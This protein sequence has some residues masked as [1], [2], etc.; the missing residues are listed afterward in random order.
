L[1][2]K[3]G[4]TLILLFA[5]VFALGLIIGRNDHVLSTVLAACANSCFDN[6]PPPPVPCVP[7]DVNADRS[8]NLSDAV[9]LLQHLFQGTPPPVPCTA[10]PQPISKIFIVRHGDRDSSPQE[11][12]DD[13]PTS[14][15]NDRGHAR[16]ARLAETLRD[17]SIHHL[18]ASDACRTVQTLRPISRASGDLPIRQIDDPADLA[19]FLLA[20]PPGKVSVVAHHS[21]SIHCLLE[22]LGLR[23]VCEID[24]DGDSYDNLLLVLLPV[25]GTPEL[26]RLHY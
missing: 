1:R 16:A 4:T 26:V 23:D 18:I 17:V 20:E 6:A 15:I 3:R 24:V 13:C 14:C 5:G 2:T 11:C 21:F 25:G 7:G 22:S 19:S 8:L 9:Y 10:N 12:P